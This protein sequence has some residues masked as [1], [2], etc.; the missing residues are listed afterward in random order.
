MERSGA[1]RNKLDDDQKVKILGWNNNK[2]LRTT[3]PLGKK[4]KGGSGAKTSLMN[5]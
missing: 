3:R 2:N 4:K 1:A 5:S